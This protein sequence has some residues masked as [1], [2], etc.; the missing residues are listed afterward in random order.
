MVAV[1]QVR[2]EDVS[3]YGILELA[4]RG[5]LLEIKDIVE[6]PARHE[7]PSNYAEQPVIF[8]NRRYL[9]SWKTLPGT[10]GEIATWR[11]P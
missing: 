5:E 7:A 10:G 2:P 4:E 3:K 8:L 1:R 6:K 11:M 9:L